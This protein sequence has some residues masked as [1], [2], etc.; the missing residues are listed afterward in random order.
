MTAIAGRLGEFWAAVDVTL[1]VVTNVDQPTA[2]GGGPSI[3][4]PGSD[5]E[6]VIVPAGAN[7]VTGIIL[8]SLVDS[9]FNGNVDELETTVHNTAGTYAA[10]TVDHSTARTYIPNFHDETLDLTLRYDEADVCQQNLL[11]CSMQSKLFY[12]WF[13]PD[14]P[15]FFGAG[16]TG[17]RQFNGAA[18]ATSFSPGSPLDDVATLDLTLRLSGSVMVVL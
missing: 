12:Y 9:T 5:P 7:A 4:T 17:A 14:G 1:G 11:Y 13:A 18:F 6:I 8:S 15:A 3:P 16:S 2:D 10:V